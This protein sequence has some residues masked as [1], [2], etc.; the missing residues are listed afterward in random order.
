MAVAY[1]KQHA[2]GGFWPVVNRGELAVLYCFL[3]L[4][5]AAHGAGVYSLDS[6]LRRTRPDRTDATTA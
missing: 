6:T 5:I 4:Y 2:P 1:F 3:Y